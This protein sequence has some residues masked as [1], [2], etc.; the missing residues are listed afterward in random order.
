MAGN[1]RKAN[2][3]NTDRSGIFAVTATFTPVIARA[4]AI[5]PF[6]EAVAVAAWIVRSTGN[7]AGL[8]SGSSNAGGPNVP[9][10]VKGMSPNLR[11]ASIFIGW[12]VLGA[13][14]SSLSILRPDTR[15]LTSEA[16]TC[17]VSVETSGNLPPASAILAAKLTSCS[18]GGT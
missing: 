13:S 11:A 12:S 14:M 5:V 8:A 4:S 16:P 17:R 2:G 15:G 3:D 10:A 18:G 6:A 9:F 7:G 1:G